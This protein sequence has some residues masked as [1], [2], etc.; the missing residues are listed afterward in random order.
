[1]PTDDFDKTVVVDVFAGVEVI[2]MYTQAQAL[3]DGV[4]VRDDELEKLAREAGFRQ[5]VTFTHTLWSACDEAPG[6]RKAWLWDV[7]MMAGVKW[8]IAVG[9]AKAKGEDPTSSG[10]HEFKL[11]IGVRVRR[12]WLLWNSHEAFVLMFPDDY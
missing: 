11:K 4:L 12:V 6:D 3:E 1:M 7:L 10:P 5:P 2:S 8:R 9:V